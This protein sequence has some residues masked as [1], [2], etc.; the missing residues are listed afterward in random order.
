MSLRSCGLRDLPH[1]HGPRRAEVRPHAVKPQGKVTFD[2]RIVRGADEA[3]IEGEW[4][5]LYPVDLQKLSKSV[6]APVV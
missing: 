1:P 5:W 4:R 3:V 2:Y 6:E